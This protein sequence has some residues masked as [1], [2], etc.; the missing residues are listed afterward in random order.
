MISV[1]ISQLPN[2]PVMDKPG[3][4]FLLGKCLKNTY[5]RLAF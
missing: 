4:W 5:G 1:D 2:V 3:S